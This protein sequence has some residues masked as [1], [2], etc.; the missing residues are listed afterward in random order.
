MLRPASTVT[1]AKI[2]EKAKVN[3]LDTDKGL[4]KKLGNFLKHYLNFHFM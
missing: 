1:M 2:F 4:I 3:S